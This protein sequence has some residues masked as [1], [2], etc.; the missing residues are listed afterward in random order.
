MAI[1]PAPLLALLQLL[2][3]LELLMTPA[4]CPL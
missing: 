1:V 3:L 4:S 2:E